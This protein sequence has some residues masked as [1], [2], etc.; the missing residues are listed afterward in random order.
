MDAKNIIHTGEEY[1]RVNLLDEITLRLISDM[2]VSL[3]RYSKK[4]KGVLTKEIGFAP[5]IIVNRK[6]LEEIYDLGGEKYITTNKT[7]K[8]G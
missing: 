6:K 8:G 1:L 4:I 7:R 3:E 5:S 2:L